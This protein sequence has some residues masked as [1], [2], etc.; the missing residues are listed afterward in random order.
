LRDWRELGESHLFTVVGELVSRTLLNYLY[1][2]NDCAIHG[3]IFLT[4][5]FWT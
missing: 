5:T 1:A 2:K 4:H 3:K